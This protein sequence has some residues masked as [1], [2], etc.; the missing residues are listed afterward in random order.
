MEITVISSADKLY[1]QGTLK[2]KQLPWNISIKYTLD[3][4]TIAPYDLAGKSGKLGID[5]KITKN[6]KVN[7]SF[8]NN[9]ALQITLALSSSLCDNIK[10]EN[11]TIAAAGAD[12]QL[13][14]SLP[15][16]ERYFASADVHD[17]EGINYHNG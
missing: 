6:S 9:Y 12:K 2:S 16:K 8:Y 10:T 14:L 7:S 15:A 11:A 5:I 13:H 17:F 3:G 1:Y 4:K